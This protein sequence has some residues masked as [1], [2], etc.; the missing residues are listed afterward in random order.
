MVPTRSF[1]DSLAGRCPSF[2]AFSS[3]LLRNRVEFDPSSWPLHRAGALNGRKSSEAEMRRGFGN[4]R[5][6]RDFKEVNVVCREKEVADLDL[7]RLA[8]IVALDSRIDKEIVSAVTHPNVRNRTTHTTHT[9]HT[10]TTRTTHT[11]THTHNDTW[12]TYR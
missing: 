3:L 2:L 11:H 9:R 8:V 12:G 1:C 10:H 6:E 5:S 4:E 7:V